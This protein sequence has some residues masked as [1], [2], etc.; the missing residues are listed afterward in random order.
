LTKAVPNDSVH[1]ARG[2]DKISRVTDAA[3]DAA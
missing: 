3:F 2:A 1:T